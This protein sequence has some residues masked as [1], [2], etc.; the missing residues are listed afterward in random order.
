[1]LRPAE[2]ERHHDPYEFA[3]QSLIVIE[4]PCVE[5][6]KDVAKQQVVQR[7]SRRADLG[8]QA[9]ELRVGESPGHE[10]RNDTPGLFL[11]RRMRRASA[12]VSAG[13]ARRW[14]AR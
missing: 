13:P 4:V 14:A 12:G 2:I 6:H 8:E 11:V 3:L 5:R 9:G 1:M 10:I 7:D